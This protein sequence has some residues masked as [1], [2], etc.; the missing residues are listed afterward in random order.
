M[1]PETALN[2]ETEWIGW[3]SFINRHR[4]NNYL[5][6]NRLNKKWTAEIK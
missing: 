1:K 2:I 5:F 4:V 6:I 3:V